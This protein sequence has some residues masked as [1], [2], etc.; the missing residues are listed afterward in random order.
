MGVPVFEIEVGFE[1]KVAA[2]LDDH[3]YEFLP[4]GKPKQQEGVHP[5]VEQYWSINSAGKEVAVLDIIE[6]NKG[7]KLLILGPLRNRSHKAIYWLLKDEV[8]KLG[9]KPLDDFNS[10]FESSERTK[11]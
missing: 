8:L 3:G 2:F 1:A 11:N 6:T 4:R 9:A 10:A 5:G 7:K